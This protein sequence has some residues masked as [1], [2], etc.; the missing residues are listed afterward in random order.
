M[1]RV[2]TGGVDTLRPAEPLPPLTNDS[3]KL[4]E[5]EYERFRDDVVAFFVSVGKRVR[6]LVLGGPSAER[7]LSLF[8][9]FR[10]ES[11]DRIPDEYH[12][13]IHDYHIASVME[14]N[15]VGKIKQRK[16]GPKVNEV[17]GQG[18][19]SVKHNML[20]K[21]SNDIQLATD[22]LAYRFLSDDRSLP[23]GF[24]ERALIPFFVENIVKTYNNVS[25]EDAEVIVRDI[26][27]SQGLTKESRVT[28]ERMVEVKNRIRWHFNDEP[29]PDR[30]D[31]DQPQRPEGMGGFDPHNPAGTPPLLERP[32]F[33][34]YELDPIDRQYIKAVVDNGKGI[35]IPRHDLLNRL[36]RL[37]LRNKK[38][39][40][41]GVLSFVFSTAFTGS[42]IGVIAALKN[43][44]YYL[45]YY[46]LWS[47]ITHGTRWVKALRAIQKAQLSSDFKLEGS[48]FEAITEMDE[49]KLRIFLRSLRY[50]CSQETLTR[51]YNSYAELEKDAERRIDM[52]AK[53]GKL[54]ELIKLEEGRARYL[55]RRESLKK[56]F[57]LYDR[58]YVTA[59]TDMK[60]M[61]REWE[62]QVDLLW[63]TKF[64][65]M[66]KS[67]LNSLFNRA[68]NDSRVTE[69]TYHLITNKSGWLKSVFPQLGKR[70]S[71]SEQ[72]RDLA[73]AEYQAILDEELPG[74]EGE[75]KERKILNEQADKV[76]DAAHVARGGAG[77]Y[78]LKWIK[79]AIS[80]T[81]T[82]GLKVG[83]TAGLTDAPKLV[84]TPYLP[85]PSVEGL[86]TFGF[87][88]MVD[89]VFEK[90]NTRI[91][92]SRFKAIKA[93]KRQ[94]TGYGPWRRWRTG[95]EEV[96]TLRRMAKDDL[97]D[98][99][100]KV[101]KL[102]KY[103][104]ELMK[105]MRL[106]KELSDRNPYARDYEYMDDYEAAVM[107]LRRQKY[108]FWVQDL[109]AGAVGT[110]HDH[111]QK[112]THLL[113][114][115]MSDIIAGG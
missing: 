18:T 87:F 88:F 103:H 17:L 78:V 71:M 97:P 47:G 81:L 11:W 23:K 35:K 112:K 111:V 13:N 66:R 85:K 9:S 1:Y 90:I 41:M 104:K 22:E 60:R 30:F 37:A 76:A 86:A 75:D 16:I 68:A 70:D 55:H 51:I 45:V 28:F 29:M 27:E 54:D 42:G 19:E 61:E 101:L 26:A 57:N 7:A 82:H 40:M 72:Q 39:G 73:L 102:H 99:V 114:Q 77:I 49:K 95:R 108:E 36:K 56:A 74:V 25:R 115:R 79:D 65:K 48:S 12:R 5:T 67:R 92:K 89:F 44:A 2:G 10:K 14:L 38:E 52:A 69:K 84:L 109:M 32:S 31:M 105:E 91:N 93:G 100:E 20:G 106:Q 64:R 113:D 46:T 98:F 80:T 63:N 8:D 6:R 43:V 53:S 94:T 110:F 24:L 21:I 96:A 15:C 50:V 58:L 33:T 83:W 62:E 4:E 34:R 3:R 107:I 59:T